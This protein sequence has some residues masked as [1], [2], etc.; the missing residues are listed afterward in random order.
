MKAKVKEIKAKINK[1]ILA[2]TAFNIPL[3]IK[4]WV[5]QDSAQKIGD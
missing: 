3:I 2:F 5:P 1:T 4:I